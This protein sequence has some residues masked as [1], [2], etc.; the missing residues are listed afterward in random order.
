MRQEL[1]LLIAIGPPLIEIN[2]YAALWLN[3]YMPERKLCYKVG[4]TSQLFQVLLGLFWRYFYRPELQR[5]QE[6]GEQLFHLA[7]SKQDPSLIYHAHYTLLATSFWLG[8]ISSAQEH[9][10]Q[11]IALNDPQLHSSHSYFFGGTDSEV[12]F[13]VYA[14]RILWLLGYPD[15]AVRKSY[16]ALTLARGISDPHILAYASVIA[17]SGFLV[18]AA[19]LRHY[20]RKPRK[21]LPF[22]VITDFRSGWHR[23]LCTGAMH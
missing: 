20:W 3:E 11:G 21:Q 2:G 13:L 6:L 17:L 19:R 9:L 18:Y 22:R 12:T 16:E 8:N 15:Q 14:A 4:E 7:Q 10:E 5:A 23:V 1:N